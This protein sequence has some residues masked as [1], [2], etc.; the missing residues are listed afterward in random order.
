[1]GESDGVAEAELADAGLQA[2]PLG[3]FAEDGQSGGGE[4]ASDD[5]PGRDQR[6][7][8][9]L[10]RQPADEGGVRGVSPALATLPGAVGDGDAVG[11]A[12]DRLPVVAGLSQL[13]LD[14]FGDGDIRIGLL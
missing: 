1:A 3:P 13:V 10:R 6:F 2:G 5:R 11:D 14:G 8:P 9:L 12:V 4:G 7:E